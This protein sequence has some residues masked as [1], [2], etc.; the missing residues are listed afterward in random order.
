MMAVRINSWFQGFSYLFI[1]FILFFSFRPSEPTIRHPVTSGKHG[2][3]VGG[4]GIRFTDVQKN[5]CNVFN[6][7]RFD[8]CELLRGH[9]SASRVPVWVQLKYRLTGSE[10]TGGD[11]CLETGC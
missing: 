9:S 6:P 1:Y 2:F 10:E 8:L 7:I 5:L 11:G 4:Q 3:Q